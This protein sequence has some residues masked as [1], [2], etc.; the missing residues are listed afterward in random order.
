MGFVALNRLMFKQKER[1]RRRR[2]RNGLTTSRPQE[3]DSLCHENDRG[4]ER[5]RYSEPKIPEDIW[6]SH[7]HSLM[8]LRD[9]ARSA[10]VSCTFLYSWRCHPKLMF[11]EE[12]LGLKHKEG[13]KVG[14]DFTNRVDHILKNHSGAGVKV[15]KLVV[16]GYCN[17]STCHLTIWL[18]YAITPGIEEVTL[19]LP[20]KYME[21]YN[22]PWSILHNGCGNSIC[23]LNLTYCAFRPTIGFDCLRSLTKLDLYQVCITGD[24]LG[25]LISNAFALEQLRLRVCSEL[26]CLKI[27]FWLERLSCLDLIWCEKLQVIECAAPNLS[28]FNIVGDPVQMSFGISQVKNISVGFSFKPNFLSCA[29]T[30]LPSVVPHLETLSIS[31]MSERIDIPMVAAKFL[32]LKL[33]KIFFSIDY[34]SFSPSYNYLSLVSF[35][36]ASP[37]LETFILSIKH[38]AAAKPDAVSG[39]NVHMRQIPGQKHDRLKKVHINGFFSAKRLVELTCHILEAAT[40]LESLTLD[41][42]HNVKEDS[43]ISRCSSVE[44]TGECRPICRDWILEAHK[45]LGVIKRYIVGRVPSSVQL[46]VGEPCSRC[47][48]I[49]AKAPKLS[50]N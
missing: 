16:P 46:N 38:L 18:Q 32:H 37:L 30:N 20:S 35:L 3:K 24:E 1:M 41:T 49:S 47:H 33:L 40:A 31:S 4:D 14:V 50:K 12:A 15:L 34:H 2:I 13:Q 8:P 27:P 45:A 36:G 5:S 17:V 25:C 21:E 43:N 22:F 6:C 28:T 44:K 19:S 29:I 42:V 10:C 23:Y 39:D 48:A 26:I 11:T 9:S 7:I